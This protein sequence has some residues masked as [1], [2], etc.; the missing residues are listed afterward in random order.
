MFGFEM[1]ASRSRNSAKSKGYENSKVVPILLQNID[2]IEDMY[3]DEAKEVI[4]ATNTLDIFVNNIDHT[5]FSD[6]QMLVEHMVDL[7]DESR[8]ESGALQFYERNLIKSLMI[9]VFRT[10]PNLSGAKEKQA[11]EK[12]A[13]EYARFVKWEGTARFCVETEN[14]QVLNTDPQFQALMNTDAEDHY[15]LEFAEFSSRLS[16]LAVWFTPGGNSSLVKE[17]AAPQ[18][19]KKKKAE[20]AV[21]VA[22]VKKQKC[23]EDV[24][25][26]YHVGGKLTTRWKLGDWS[27]MSEEEKTEY[28]AQR[29]ARGNWPTEVPPCEQWIHPNGQI[30]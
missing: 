4:S 16:P 14:P 29:G 7:V 28:R 21:P 17:V 27:K 15:L 8:D 13:R 19:K 1:R 22:K 23:S 25:K 9:D 20:A 30:F 11:H 12:A 2:R 10:F 26:S 6:T 24:Q 5:G 3:S 18:K